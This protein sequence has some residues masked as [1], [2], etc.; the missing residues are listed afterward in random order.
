MASGGGTTAIALACESCGASLHAVAGVVRCESCGHDQR[1]SPEQLKRLGDYQ[2]KFQGIAAQTQHELDAIA[3]IAAWHGGIRLPSRKTLRALALCIGSPLLLAG[4]LALLALAAGGST[5]SARRMAAPIAS[6]GCELGLVVFLI[7]YFVFRQEKVELPLAKQPSLCPNCGAPMVFGAG[8]ILAHCEYCGSGT[9]ASRAVVNSSLDAAKHAA[10]FMRIER[11]RSERQV[12]L[13][14]SGMSASTRSITPLII[15]ASFALPV[16]GFAIYATW[17]WATG[18]ENIPGVLL[19]VIWP[20]AFAF[21]IWG[22]I[23]LSRRR[24]LKAQWC[25]VRERVATGLRGFAAH[26][27]Q[28]AMTWLDSYWPLPFPPQ[29]LFVELLAGS[30]VGSYR[31][32]PVLLLLNPKKP[33]EGS[34]AGDATILLAA[35]LDPKGDETQLDDCAGMVALRSRLAARGYQ[36]K[37]FGGGI[38]ATAKLAERDIARGS[39]ELAATLL[40]VVD[41]IGEFASGMG[42]AAPT[43]LNCG[44][45]IIQL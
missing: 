16:I 39:A 4:A 35:E 19:L 44:W 6:N 30:I 31:G 27:S 15:G 28:G 2:E 8:E 32:Y 29:L 34:I 41:D 1:L 9:V 26:G 22:K 23:H 24:N 10:R 37:I 17:V 45:R 36:A 3:R 33:G 38:H 13:A 40:A 21:P 11:Y 42:A 18:A 43:P 12:C 14:Y 7:W 5:D 25:S 20:A